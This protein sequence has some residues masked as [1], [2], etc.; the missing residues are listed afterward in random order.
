MSET[1]TT[2][3]HGDLPGYLLRTL[4]LYVSK[5]IRILAN[6]LDLLPR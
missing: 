5:R 1:V 6:N 2:R 3:L 4:G